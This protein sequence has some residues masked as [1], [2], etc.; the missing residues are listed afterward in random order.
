MSKTADDCR[1]FNPFRN[2]ALNERQKSAF[3]TF[4][5]YKASKTQYPR[6]Q[7]QPER[8]SFERKIG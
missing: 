5:A 8:D 6:L 1:A 3:G 4:N 7:G 2:P